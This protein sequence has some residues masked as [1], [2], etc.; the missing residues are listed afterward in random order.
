MTFIIWLLLLPVFLSTHFYFVHV[1]L[2]W[3][4]LF[5]HVHR[6]HHRN[7]QIGPWAGMSMHPIEHLLYISSVLV[8][9]VIPSH[10]VI[11]LLHL[12]TR[13][14]A[15]AFSHTGFEKVVT[16]D[17]ILTEAADFHHQLHHK[18]F[19]C[20]YG[21]VDAPWDRWM[22]TLHDGSDAATVVIRERRRQLRQQRSV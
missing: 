5:D 14:M 20:N 8:H 3:P 16:K 13:C 4:P 10:P 17:K 2:H 7:V 21:T 19:D 12:Y 22:G 18:F 1:L 9:F 15:P 11:V 6:L